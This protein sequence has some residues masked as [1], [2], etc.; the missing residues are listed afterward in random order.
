[1]GTR[2]SR[3]VVL[4]TVSAALLA[5]STGTASSQPAACDPEHPGRGAGVCAEPEPTP[6]PEAAPTE[7][8]T[9]TPA[10]TPKLK[11]PTPTTTATPVPTVLAAPTEAPTAAP[12]TTATATVTASPTPAETPTAT[13]RGLPTEIPAETP[14]GTPSETPA[15]RPRQVAPQ[16]ASTVT[17]DELAPTPT[18]RQLTLPRAAPS[19]TPDAEVLGQVTPRGSEPLAL[20]G[21]G[22]LLLALI[23]LFVVVMG[24][25][26]VDWRREVSAPD[27][28]AD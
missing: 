22:G 5:V 3:W 8:A 12:T 2:A 26:F 17:P 16:G 20:T 1:M 11:P 25:L 15:E 28:G 4:L 9:A 19:S 6:T 24:W 21:F 14:S 10:P 27:R 18:P 7:T 13:S 23:A